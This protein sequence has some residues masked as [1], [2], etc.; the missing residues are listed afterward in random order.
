[1]G[2]E[3]NW[4]GGGEDLGGGGGGWRGLGGRGWR[5]RGERKCWGGDDVNV[6]VSRFLIIRFVTFFLLTYQHPSNKTPQYSYTYFPS[7]HSLF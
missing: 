7:Q 2:E 4:G 1:M 5:G 3:G 6:P